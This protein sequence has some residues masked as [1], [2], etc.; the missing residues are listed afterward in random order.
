MGILRRLR[1]IISR[2]GESPV[3]E[4]MSEDETDE[5]YEQ[6]EELVKYYLWFNVLEIEKQKKENQ[7]AR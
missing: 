6:D 4:I 3:E 2:G 7:C 1:A 5:P